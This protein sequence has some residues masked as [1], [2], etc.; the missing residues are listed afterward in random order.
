MPTAPTALPTRD[1]PASAPDWPILRNALASA[2]QELIAVEVPGP[3]YAQPLIEAVTATAV[4]R[5][6][7]VL[8]FDALADAGGTLLDQ[9]RG[10]TDSTQ[11]ESALT[12]L[13]DRTLL[14]V[15]P[16]EP[17]KTRLATFWRAVNQHREGWS[18]LP[19]QTI[20]V[21]SRPGYAAL[22]EHAL[23]LKRWMALKLHLLP[24]PVSVSGGSPLASL[25]PSGRN[26]DSEIPAETGDLARLERQ[27]SRAEQAGETGPALTTRYLQPLLNAAIAAGRL[28]RVREL[29]ARIQQEGWPAEAEF[30]L[31]KSASLGYRSLGDFVALADVERRLIAIAQRLADSDPTNTSWQRDL[32]ISFER[33]GDL[34]TAQG[35]LP[36]AKRHFTAALA[37]RQRLA[38]SNPTNT[39][40]Q[41]NLSISFNKLGDLARTQGKLP[42]AE[43]H[44]AAALAIAQRLADFDPANA[45]WQRDL[46]ISFNKLGDLAIAQGKLPDA[47]RHFTAA[48]GIAQRL[49]NSDLA[50]ADWQRDLSVSFSKLGNLATAQGKLPDA[51]RHFNAALAIAQRLANSDP[52]NAEWQR[53]L[54]ISLNK[55]GD[56]ATDQGQ[57]PVAERHF[58]AALTI[59]QR[60]A[61]SDPANTDWQR[62]LSVV[63]T[64]LAQLHEEQ[65]DQAQ[66][67]RLAETSL[68]IDER[69][70]ALDPTNATWQNDARISRALVARLQA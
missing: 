6:L 66:A 43:R 31:L 67:L 12:F 58:A 17:T 11:V 41:R 26:L 50:N 28:P 48:L 44:F 51:E 19:G 38:D 16:D 5:L 14:P 52:A 62:D 24:P 56:L 9:A 32:S 53:D 70:A 54:S 42:E 18:Q 30:S 7:R 15:L 65:G 2:V 4:G 34:A 35:K 25:E 3:E 22:N 68:A 37:I 61:D 20:F 40:A 1:F 13:I 29:L 59:R 47:E 8:P 39:D 36:D 45:N 63:L 57:L 49:A 60:L 23:H 55:L 69:L 27:L 21:L 10:Q 64:A 46:S 33:L